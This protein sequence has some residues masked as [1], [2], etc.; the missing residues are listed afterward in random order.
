MSTLL[1]EVLTLLQIF[2]IRSKVE[3]IHSPLD[4]LD[5]TE[6]E[7]NTLGVRRTR[8]VD[9]LS[10]FA[11]AHVLESEVLL[12]TFRADTSI[13][14]FWRRPDDERV[15]AWGERLNLASVQ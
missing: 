8:Q 5:G 4:A 3:H 12:E 11:L 13:D 15:R 10:R 6:H 2:N 7:R 1:G 9:V 14:D